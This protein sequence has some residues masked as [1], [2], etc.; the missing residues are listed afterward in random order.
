M[1]SES[2]QARETQ[3][4]YFEKAIKRRRRLLVEK[5]V[6]KARIPKDPHL[7]HLQAKLRQTAKRLRALKALE[8][9]KEALAHRKQKKREATE[10]QRP[11]GSPEESKKKSKKGKKEG[12]T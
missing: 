11:E 4:E 12:E 8:E 6:D 10:A 3:K 2:T 9:Q 5:G 7:K 1:P